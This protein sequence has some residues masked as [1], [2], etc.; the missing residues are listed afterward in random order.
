MLPRNIAQSLERPRALLR[1]KQ[2]IVEPSHKARRCRDA[3]G[4]RVHSGLGEI[5][6]GA[7]LDDRRR[8]VAE[9]IEKHR[10][11]FVRADKREGVDGGSPDLNIRIIEIRF[12][13]LRRVH[14]IYAAVSQCA[15]HP[16]RPCPLTRISHGSLQH[17][18]AAFSAW[19]SV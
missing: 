15:K 19:D 18:N 4:L 13:D 7:F 14:G 8:I 3:L 12:D 1:G 16:E 9:A 17:H 11:R 10:N 2:R 5:A 6:S